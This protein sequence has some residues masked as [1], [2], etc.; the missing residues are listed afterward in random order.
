MDIETAK[1]IL[2]DNFNAKENTF[3]FI[4]YER[5]RFP[6]EEFW[7]V[8][9]SIECLV[10]NKVFSREL[11]EQVSYCYERFLK[12]LIYHCD[13]GDSHGLAYL[14]E[15]SDVYI[16]RLDYIVTAFYRVYDKL[17]DDSFFELE[18]YG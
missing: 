6:K 15:N 12:E 9:D 16:D 3:T 5:S 4:M 11:A 10:K 14:P 1:Q 7:M 18:R 8:Y 13:G 2:S 17:L